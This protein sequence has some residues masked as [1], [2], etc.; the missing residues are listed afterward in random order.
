MKFYDATISDVLCKSDNGTIH[1]IDTCLRYV[2]TM[3]KM[4]ESCTVS[5]VADCTFTN[6]QSWSLCV[7]GC[8]G[9]R[10]RSRT[11]VS[12]LE[13]YLSHKSQTNNIDEDT[14]PSDCRNLAKHPQYEQEPCLCGELSPVVLGDWSECILEPLETDVRLPKHISRHAMRQTRNASNF[15]STCGS[16]YRYKVIACKN[17]QNTIETALNCKVDDYDKELCM[18]PCPVDCVMSDWSEWTKCPSECGAGV[19][20]R[21]RHIQRLPSA[22]GRRCPSLDGTSKD[23]QTRLCHPECTDYLWNVYDWSMCHMVNANGHTTGTASDHF[24]SRQ[25]RPP[26]TRTCYM[27]C[28]GECVVSEWTEWTVC[29]QLSPFHI[30]IGNI[31]E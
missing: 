27:P 14:A 15:D 2:G 12:K 16:G 6:W 31:E 8:T 5:C 11:L 22:G 9:K 3:P 4:S 18:I 13:F 23:V 29:Q 19:Q 21:F 1:S 17:D 10:F 25:D 20:Q 30:S 28:L 7:G 26:N 24:C